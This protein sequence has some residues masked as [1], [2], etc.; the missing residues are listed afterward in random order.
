MNKD[1]RPRIFVMSPLR[2]FGN[3]TEEQNI[4]TAKLVCRE[5]AL[6]G[7]APFAPHLLYT[8]FLDDSVEDERWCGIES[9]LAFLDI[10]DFVLAFTKWGYTEGMRHELKA[11]KT[12][13]K[14]VLEAENYEDIK[15]AIIE[16]IS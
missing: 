11:A 10:C 9:G 1:R 13:G 15:Q 8:R 2:A 6:A 14:L 16:T 7:G 5:V 3:R 12:K 4:E